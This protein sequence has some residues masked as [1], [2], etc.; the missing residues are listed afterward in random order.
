MQMLCAVLLVVAQLTSGIAIPGHMKPLGS[1]APPEGEIDVRDGFPQPL[2]FFDKYVAPVRPVLFRGA[3]KEIKGYNLWTDEYM[4]SN[5]GKELVEVEEGKKEDR[6]LSM[7]SETFGDFLRKYQGKDPNDRFRGNFYSVS[8][9]AQG[10]RKEYN[11]PAAVDCPAYYSN[12]HGGMRQINHWFS[13]GGTSSVLHRDGFENI[14]CLFDGNKDLIFIPPNYTPEDLH[15]DNRDNH[16]HSFID[17]DKVDMVQYPKFRNVKWWKAHMERGDCLYIPFGWF[18]H[19]KS[20]PGENQR[21]FAMN[22]WWEMDKSPAGRKAV[23]Q[24]KAAP[25]QPTFASDI[26]FSREQL[27]EVP[28]S[29]EYTGRKGDNDGDD[30]YDGSGGDL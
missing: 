6:D 28:E 15:W 3:A 23:A 16:G 25:S 12:S 14:N 29:M 8:A 13:S 4:S 18:H 10:M 20:Y 5:F 17:C 26:K 30:D 9:V 27:P 7:W 19:V 1:H 24:C 22:L 2:E 11:M 21:N